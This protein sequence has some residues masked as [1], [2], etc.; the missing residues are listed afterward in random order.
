MIDLYME[1]LSADYE[2]VCEIMN[3]IGQYQ[4]FY[5]TKA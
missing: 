2:T 4:R 5:E 3:H 1:A